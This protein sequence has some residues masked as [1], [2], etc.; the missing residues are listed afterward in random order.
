MTDE[1]GTK[2]AGRHGQDAKDQINIGQISCFIQ[3]D[4]DM[5]F[6]NDAEI[7]LVR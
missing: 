3:T 5:L 6:I 7:Y 1:L 4:T 2:F